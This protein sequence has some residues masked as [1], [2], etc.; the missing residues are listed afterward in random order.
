MA[1][2]CW[3]L[4]LVLPLVLLPAGA[5]AEP[6]APVLKAQSAILM[7]AKQVMFYMATTFTNTSLQPAPQ[8]S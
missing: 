1:R 6:K 4:A 2:I 3:F 8:K 7:D 5:E